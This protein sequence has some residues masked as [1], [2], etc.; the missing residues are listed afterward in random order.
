MSDPGIFYLL[1]KAHNN[2]H[3][4][5]TV[6]YSH[7]THD[8]IALYRALT[9]TVVLR[10]YFA[11]KKTLLA[12]GF[13]PTTFQTKFLCVVAV[14]VFMVVGFLMLSPQVGPFDLPKS[15]DNYE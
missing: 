5:K 3:M 9:K 14:L 2:H 13:E 8:T 12:L 10:R 15:T 6:H 4:W 1:S 7:L 11:C